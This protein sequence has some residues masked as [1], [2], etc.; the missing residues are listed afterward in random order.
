MNTATTIQPIRMTAYKLGEL[1]AGSRFYFH[2]DS[3][4][5]VWVVEEQSL[6]VWKHGSKTHRLETVRVYNRELVHINKEVSA[7]KTVIFLNKN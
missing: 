7:T 1:P 5:I 4:R 3:K 6:K 2:G